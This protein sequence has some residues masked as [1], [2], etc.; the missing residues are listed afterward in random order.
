MNKNKQAILLLEDGSVHKG[1]SFGWTG[2]KTGEVVFNTAL[3]GYEEILTD[4]SYCGQIVTM[5]Y[6]QI[7]N[8]GISLKDAESYKIWAEGIIVREHSKTYSNYRASIS[9]SEYLKKNKIV[10]IEGIDTR[11]LVRRIREKGSMKGLIAANNQ[12]ISQLKK[13]LKDAPSIAQVDLVSKV[14]RSR[15]SVFRKYTPVLHKGGATVV[16]IDYGTK[17]NIINILQS[18]GV[19]TKVLPGNAELKDVLKFKPDGVVLSNGPGD[20]QTVKSGI[21]LSRDLIAYN[22]EHYLPVMGICLGHQLIGLGSGAK[23]YKLKFGHHGGNH[24]IKDL[25]TNKIEITVQNHNFCVDQKSLHK[26]FIVT[27]INLND[28]TVEGVK[29]KKFPIIS[30]QYHPEG[31]PG[32][33]DSKYLFKKFYNLI[34]SNKGKEL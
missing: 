33:H 17:L 4:P 18:F 34:S 21:K 13:R 22:N 25:E 3:T 30:Y 9:L 5:C 20:P 28:N 31:A 10:G 29:H 19:N 7:G 6:P 27:H 8:Y 23:T 32:P 12:D 24:P 16:I 15:Y 14:N 26:D 2:E 1:Q 11:A